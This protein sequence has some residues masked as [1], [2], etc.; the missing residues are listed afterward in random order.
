MVYITPLMYFLILQFVNRLHAAV[1][2]SA[3]LWCVFIF[4]WGQSFLTQDPDSY[5][6]MP[7]GSAAVLAGVSRSPLNGECAPD[8]R[9]SVLTQFQADF[10]DRRRGVFAPEPVGMPAYAEIPVPAFSGI[11][12]P[13]EIRPAPRFLQCCRRRAVLRC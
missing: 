8:C 10:T 11:G 12:T 6:A 2:L 9:L 4:L 7:T 1:R 13:P 3:V 5:I